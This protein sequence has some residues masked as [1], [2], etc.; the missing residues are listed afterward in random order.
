MDRLMVGA[1]S[2]VRKAC[3]PATGW[4]QGRSDP[5]DMST[6]MSNSGRSSLR[7]RLFAVGLQGR[8]MMAVAAMVL[9]G[10][11]VLTYRANAA[12]SDAYRWTA[13]AQAA[14]IARAYAFGLTPADLASEARLRKRAQRLTAVHPDLMSA[15]IV[16]A[17]ARMTHAR[18]T[19]T[20]ESGTMVFPLV[21]A[22]DRAPAAL[23]LEFRL[24]EHAAA[25]AAGHREVVLTA[26]GGALLLL[27]GLGAGTWFL[28]VS[29]VE[30]LS[31]S[32][33][34]VASGR[35][36]S[37][38]RW[39]RRDAVGVLAGSVDAL[40]GAVQALQARIAG[41]DREDP[42][43]GAL[44]HRALH[45]AL[46]EMLSTARDRG[47]KVSVVE[48]DIDHFQSLNDRRGHAAGDEALRIA[49]RLI[50]GEL[51]PGDVC[52]RIGGDEFL[53]ALHDTDA[54]AAER[55]VQRLR[56]AIATASLPDGLPRPAFSAGIAE[57][58]RDARDQHGLMR[59]AEGALYR[60][61]RSGRNRCVVYS[62]FVDAPLSLQEEADRARTA[63]LANT[64][65]ALAR[66]VDL[67]DGY[68][69]QHS[70]RVAQYG[71]VLARE[72]GMSEEEI[73]QIR[74]AGILHDVGK[75]GVAD[76][77]LLKPAR[78]T[79]DEFLEMQ[80]HSTLGRDIVEG[81]GMP[82]IAEWVLYLHE[83]WDGR[84]YPERL[85]GED[86]PLAS[87]VLGVADAFEAMTSSRL[88]RRGMPV[89][90][91]LDELERSA[92][93]QFDPQVAQRMVE[94]V[95]SG[96]IPLGEIGVLDVTHY[97][98]AASSLS[99]AP[100]EE[101]GEPVRNLPGEPSAPAPRGAMRAGRGS[102]S[103]SSARASSAS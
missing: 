28:V 9:L 91:A 71:A 14:A 32:A 84:G 30:R 57:F 26:V 53:L 12:I 21:A 102:G 89:E 99:A 7:Q 40:G 61:K 50:A 10:G 65:Y 97:G 38:L 67:K 96:A 34:L 54:W 83:R 60:A 85:A 33:Q 16:P 35:P 37:A 80:R 68:T 63:G 29:P 93:A 4:V 78:L 69:H 52:G 51:R 75:V 24:T 87:R 17:D 13:E 59:L 98:S 56:Q 23:R 20:G 62:S 55:V 73:D 103:A 49:A 95:R 31:R 18:W 92:G 3:N 77:V 79:N 41:L 74:T 48:L 86:I 6:S 8:L 45:D 81:A 44:N 47:T 43:T 39:R 100:P 5:A 70:A 76:A 82:E 1:R 46:H 88:Y 27:I 58:P 72:M 42:L 101:E 25:R 11:G 36:A 15:A 2:A 66:A 90:K 22:A 64:V 19:Q 94:L